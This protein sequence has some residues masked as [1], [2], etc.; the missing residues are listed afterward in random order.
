VV[1]IGVAMAGPFCAMLLGDYG[2]KV[3]KVERVGIGDDSRAWPPFF[4]NAIGH[5]FVAANRNKQSVAVDLK[6]AEGGE[7]VR[8]LIGEADVVVDNYRVGALARAGLGYEALAAMNPR[9]I[10]CS[11]SGFGATGPL[12]GEPANDLFMQ[13]FA[14]GMSITGEI[15]G[16]PVKMGLSVADLGAGMLGTIGILMALEARH[17]TGRGQRVETSLLEGQ[18][19]MLSYHLTK[20]FS[21]GEVPGPSGSGALTSPIYR[22]FKASDD[23]VVISAFNERM[24]RDLCGALE[25][26]EWADDPCFCDARQRAEHRDL[27]IGMIGEV[28]AEDSVAGW[29]KRLKVA[30]VPCSPIKRIDKAVRDE[31]VLARDM[32]VQLELPGLGPIRMAGLPLKFSETPGRIELHPPRLGQHTAEVMRRLGYTDAAIEDLAARG[33]VGL[34]PGWC[35]VTPAKAPE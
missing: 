21:S 14:G 12:S 15:G 20:F 18:L 11:I 22:A 33:V 10:Y 26:P 24:W 31:Q 32:V 23:W 25:R 1:E 3:V 29:Q 27:L 30:G 2:A 6:H 4:H 8:R 7:V 35:P 5:Y 13:A 34:D 16:G 9:L 19:A 17:R 28:M